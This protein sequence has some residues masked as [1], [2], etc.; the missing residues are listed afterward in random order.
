MKETESKAVQYP[1]TYPSLKRGDEMIIGIITSGGDSPG[2]NMAVASVVKG[3]LA[4]GIRP[5]GVRRGYNGILGR[6]E[7]LT[8]E[9]M[10]LDAHIVREIENRAGTFLKTD[11][12]DEFMKPEVQQQAVD[13]LRQIGVDALVVIGG[14]GSFNG[15]LRLVE[16]GFPCVCIPATIDN[17]LGYSEITLGFDTAV[18]DCV[19]SVRSI[20]ATS[21]SMG[22]PAVVEVMGRHCGEI[23]LHTAMATGAEILVV[24][25]I[26]W[27]FDEIAARLNQELA[28]G[29]NYATI[30]ASENCWDNRSDMDFNWQDFLMNYP[31][32][33]YRKKDV[34]PGERM[35]VNRMAS[36]LKR[37]C[38]MAEV[39]ATTV[40]YSQ[41]GNAPTGRDAA[42]AF[43]AG[44]L[45]VSL[46]VR[47]RY[48]R[49]IGMRLGRI[50]HIS[51]T[52]ALGIPRFFNYENYD[53]INKQ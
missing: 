12:C 51:I 36:V 13:H 33:K 37:K 20:R 25:E 34:V 40:G 21:R 38:H 6:A 2:M 26:K 4:N 50:Y 11:R 45:A 41:R 30:I 47:K 48:N 23:A 27:S 49:A 46:L 28:M 35:T 39:R 42:F 44:Q 17:D 53:Q 29:N 1:R 8:D 9:I 7:N 24:P 10:E 15:A 5:F 16:H 43:E 52:E 3:C 14:D 32:E 22:R 19:D 18:N 31:D